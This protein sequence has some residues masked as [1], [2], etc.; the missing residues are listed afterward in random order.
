M[1]DVTTPVLASSGAL[2]SERRGAARGEPRGRRSERRAEIT[3]LLVNALARVSGPDKLR[4]RQLRGGRGRPRCRCA[5]A[6]FAKMTGTRCSR[7]SA[8]TAVGERHRP[9]RER[10]GVNAGSF[11]FAFESNACLTTTIRSVPVVPGGT[12]IR[13][14]NPIEWVGEATAVG[15]GRAQ[16]QLFPT[17]LPAPRCPRPPKRCSL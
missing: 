10:D 11:A 4:S 13:P 5:S 3:W 16:T 8:R 6:R 17:S 7:T 14:A 12:Y 1:T 9:W 2:A 15:P